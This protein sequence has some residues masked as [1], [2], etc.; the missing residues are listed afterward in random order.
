MV[1][2]QKDCSK[3]DRSKSCLLAIETSSDVLSVAI[4]SADSYFVKHI[5][6]DK[7]HNQ[8]LLPTIEAGL[9]E[10]SLSL[11]A[12]DAFVYGQ[13]PGSF[14]GLRISL[15]VIQGL[16]FA[17]A[18]PVIPVSSLAAL[19]Y[20]VGDEYT[21]IN[22]LSVIDARMDEFYW[23][24][25]QKIVSPNGSSVV[26]NIAND[27]LAKLE[28]NSINEVLKPIPSAYIAVGS[29]WPLLENRLD[30]FSPPVSVNPAL[31]PHAR[32]LLD[33]AEQ[34]LMLGEV[35]PVHLADVNYLRDKTPWKKLAEQ[36]K[37][38]GI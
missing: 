31:R 4:K 36:G 16:A 19:A 8:L 2:N 22:I 9:S 28:A 26:Q 34:K 33:I 30:S 21:G 12:V 5:Q 32:A 24:L 3:K 15:S 38:L 20:Q 23:G 37:P 10:L 1:K 6:A 11:S 18:K 7:Q 27:Q 14:T 17:V 25:Y 29:G 35:V 13:G